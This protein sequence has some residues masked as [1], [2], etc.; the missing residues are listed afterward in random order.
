MDGFNIGCVPGLFLN[1]CNSI[2]GARLKAK[3]KMR[4][5]NIDINQL[6][7]LASNRVIRRAVVFNAT[8]LREERHFEHQAE[9]RKREVLK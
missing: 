6:E 2:H 3:T 4:K 8:K 5:V 1:L 7:Q 9:K